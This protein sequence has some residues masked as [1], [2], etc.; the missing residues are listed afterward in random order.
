MSEF[1]HHNGLEP[2][3]SFFIKA[4]RDLET[5]EKARHRG[6]EET[7][8]VDSTLRM[9]QILKRHHELQTG[10]QFT[11]ELQELDDSTDY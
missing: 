8:S 7:T 10:P 4:R 6:T 3:E 9:S 5:L 2:P 1:L 11:Q